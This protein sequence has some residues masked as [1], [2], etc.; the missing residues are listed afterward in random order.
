MAVLVLSGPVG[1]GK[2][3]VARELIANA[4]EGTAYLEGD[5]FWPFLVE[6]KIGQSIQARFFMTMRA[7]F[8]AA[9]HYHRDDYRFLLDF[10]VPPDFL[11]GARKLLRDTPF[12]FVVL[13]PP[14]EVCAERAASRG[15]GT[16]ADYAAY[17]EFYADFDIDE[18]YVIR[19]QLS[20]AD[21]ADL[22]RAEVAGGRFRVEAG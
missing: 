4:P 18:P 8:A 13:L 20:A 15:E 6:T 1:A 3:T 7:M 21:M 16:I 22:I 10:S 9:W 14:L 17:R 19:D 2:T 11:P 5:A 12:D